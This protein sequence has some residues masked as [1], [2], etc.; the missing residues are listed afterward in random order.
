VVQALDP[1]ARALRFA[2]GH[3]SEGFL[4]DELERRRLLGY[5][6]YSHLIRLV[7]S[8][9]EPGRET[10]AAAA[11]GE[12]IAGSATVLGPA[13]LFR[14]KERDRAQLLVKSAPDP[15]ARAA[16]VRAVRVAVEEVSAAREHR[17]V[18]FSV[19]VDPG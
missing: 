9:H 15:G 2:A 3:D 17:K 4:A 7:C 14:L 16:S 19:D 10:R 8:S 13:P 18:A 12:R 11:V 1:G 5:P 6:P